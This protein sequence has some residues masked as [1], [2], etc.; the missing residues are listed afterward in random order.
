MHSDE[1]FIVGWSGFIGRQ[2]ISYLGKEYPASKIYLFNRDEYSINIDITVE[3]AELLPQDV[4]FSKL[5]GEGRKTVLYLA[6]SYSPTDSLKYAVDSATDNI[7]PFIKFLEKIKNNAPAIKFIFASSGGTIY[8]DT[9]GES[10]KESH[11]LSPKNIYAANKIAQ[12]YYLNVYGINYLL[13]YKILRIANPYGP[14]QKLKGGQGLIPAVLESL[15]CMKT[16]SIY[17]DGQATRDYIYIDDLCELI[18]RTINY[19]G[20]HKIFNAGSGS[21]HSIMDIINCFDSICEHK[22]KYT[23]KPS[24]NSIVNSIVLDIS[25]ARKELNWEPRISLVDGIREF[26]RWYKHHHE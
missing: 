18:V 10:C 14:G 7:V 4:F 17:G 24:E 21:A 23:Y 5:L 12:E 3:Q 16:L 9:N 20:P 1:I 25:L 13:D 2:F 15:C 11:E 22:V 8:G 6:N 26:I 19:Q